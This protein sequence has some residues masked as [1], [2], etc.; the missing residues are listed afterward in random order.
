MAKKIRALICKTTNEAD[1]HL[2]AVK[3]PP[4]TYNKEPFLTFD[5]EATVNEI[6]HNESGLTGIIK[7][8]QGSCYRCNISSG[9]DLIIPADNI[10]AILVA[11]DE[12]IGG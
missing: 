3:Q 7:N 10:S 4:L 11:E 8:R 1:V 9:Y 6:V 12:V 5:P 2:I